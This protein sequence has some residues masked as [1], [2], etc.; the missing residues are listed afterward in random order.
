MR[1]CQF[2]IYNGYFINKTFSYDFVRSREN[3]DMHIL[4]MHR[5]YIYRTQKIFPV[6]HIDLQDSY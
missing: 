2:A 6:R 1:L 5:I 3:F 4:Y